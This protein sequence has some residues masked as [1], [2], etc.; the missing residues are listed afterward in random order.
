LDLHHVVERFL[1]GFSLQG[2]CELENFGFI[3][4]FVDLAERLYGPEAHWFFGGD[5]EGFLKLIDQ[6]FI[7]KSGGECDP[8][9]G[10]MIGVVWEGFD[11]LDR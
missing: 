10:G 3:Q 7:P 2:V 11:P 5:G 1:P 6:M 4:F 8:G 9:R